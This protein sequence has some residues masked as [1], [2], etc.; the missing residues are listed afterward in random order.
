MLP[1]ALGFLSVNV[2]DDPLHV[3]LPR[4]EGL[5]TAAADAFTRMALMFGLSMKMSEKLVLVMKGQCCAG[6]QRNT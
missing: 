6:F 2:V 5:L 3:C 4:H 1:C